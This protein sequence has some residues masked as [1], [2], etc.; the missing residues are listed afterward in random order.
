LITQ[1]NAYEILPGLFVNG[2]RTITENVADQGGIKMAYNMYLQRKRQRGE[3]P[4][5]GQLNGDQQFFVSF[6]QSWCVKQ[7]EEYLRTLLSSDVHGPAEFRV[8]ISVMNR[9]EFAQVF[10]CRTGDPMVPANRCDI[11]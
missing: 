5:F 2:E 11:W 7:T 10:A 6:A 9:P 1:A 3:T 4:N 8:N